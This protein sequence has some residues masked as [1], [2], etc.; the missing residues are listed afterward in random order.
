MPRAFWKGHL[1]LSLVTCAVALYPVLSKAGR[2]KFHRINRQT[3]R[4]L[5]QQMVEPDTLEAPEAADVA[6]GYEVSPALGPAVAQ[7]QDGE[8]MAPPRRRQA[9]EERAPAPALRRYVEIEE[10]ELEKIEIENTHIIDIEHFVP[11]SEID[12]RYL[13][14]SYY[15]V[16][17]SEAGQE[18]YAVIRDAMGERNLAG[19]ARVVLSKREHAVMLESFGKGL[20]AVIL[21]YPYELRDEKARFDAI[22]ELTLPREMRQL[23]LHIVDRMT[24]RFDPSKIEDRYKKALEE[25]IAAKASRRPRPSATKKPATAQVV[26][27]MDA[28]RASVKEKGG[29]AQKPRR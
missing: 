17:T 28:L 10:E 16:P 1:K 2:P 24:G 15:A 22:Q 14:A 29:G 23:A 13:N 25:L 18:A 5:R 3:G 19:L 27:L 21:H 11:R 8:E 6:R 9:A 26:N 7:A 12:D 20:L 4:R